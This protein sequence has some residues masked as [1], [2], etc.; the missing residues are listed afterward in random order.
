VI[1]FWNSCGFPWR[2]GPTISWIPSDIDIFFLVETWQH[3]ES[4][5]PNIEGVVPESVLKT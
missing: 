2:K 4:K 1:L 5:V 3:D